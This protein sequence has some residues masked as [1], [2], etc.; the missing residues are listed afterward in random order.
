[1]LMT[2]QN[3]SG[4]RKKAK[5]DSGEDDDADAARLLSEDPMDWMLKNEQVSNMLSV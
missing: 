2:P 4:T 1:M 3:D 5:G